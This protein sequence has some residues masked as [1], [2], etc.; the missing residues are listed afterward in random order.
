MYA[1]GTRQVIYTVCVRMCCPTATD[2]LIGATAFLGQ[3]V[4]HMHTHI[5]TNILFLSLTHSQMPPPGKVMCIIR[6]V[7]PLPPK[8][9]YK[10]DSQQAVTLALTQDGGIP[11][12]VLY[13]V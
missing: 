12:V 13:K 7:A 3:T 9:K 8:S 6:L 2:L 5:Q 11:S 1:T 4:D 10:H